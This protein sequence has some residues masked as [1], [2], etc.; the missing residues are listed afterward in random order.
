LLWSPDHRTRN[1][2]QCKPLKPHASLTPQVT[3]APSQAWEWPALA[4]K[5]YKEGS[6]DLAVSRPPAN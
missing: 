3:K 6:F 4:R 2:K 5:L 1:K